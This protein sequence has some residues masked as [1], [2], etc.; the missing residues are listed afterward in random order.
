MDFR[1]TEEQTMLRQMVRKFAQNEVKPLSREFDRKVDPK[2]CFPWEL[3]KKASKLGLRTISIPAEY[4]GGGVKDLLSYMVLM[5]ELGA[6]DN[7]FGTCI[8]QVVALAAWMDVLCNQEQ[9]DEFFPKIVE[10]DTFVIAVGQ[11][12]P[13]SGTDNFLMLDVPGAETKGIEIA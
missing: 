12:E 9:K 10:D 2:E 5:E 4:G 3:L 6:G 8:N 11:T 13:N 1:E 7:G